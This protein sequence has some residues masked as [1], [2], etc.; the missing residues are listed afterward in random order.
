MVDD[1]LVGGEDND[2]QPIVAN[3]LPHVLGRVQKLWGPAKVKHHRGRYQPW[4]LSCRN[5]MT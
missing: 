1:L 4:S 3:E 5:T 2:R